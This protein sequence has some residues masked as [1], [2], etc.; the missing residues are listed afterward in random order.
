M[1]GGVLRPVEACAEG[2]W[3]GTTPVRGF[4]PTMSMTSLLAQQEG[5]QHEQA[6]REPSARRA[7]TS[8]Q[9]D[10]VFPL[11]FHRPSTIF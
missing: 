4:L 2:A 1:D 5:K 8:F 3:L 9:T 11:P 10:A 7:K 6:S